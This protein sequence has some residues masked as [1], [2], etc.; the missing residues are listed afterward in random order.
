VLHVVASEQL[1]HRCCFTSWCFGFAAGTTTGICFTPIFTVPELLLPC[2]TMVGA[3]GIRR[4]T[5]GLRKL[6]QAGLRLLQHDQ[7]EGLGP[8][9][10]TWYCFIAY[11]IPIDLSIF[12]LMDGPQSMWTSL[13]V[14]SVLSTSDLEQHPCSTRSGL[15]HKSQDWSLGAN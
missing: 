6:I 4:I 9:S 12:A 14:F 10:E 8:F 1:N 15:G 7:R 5:V 13:A 11:N 3:A 2:T